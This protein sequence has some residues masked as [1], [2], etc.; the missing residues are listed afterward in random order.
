MKALVSKQPIRVEYMTL[1][2]LKRALRNPKAH[3]L[4]VIDASIRRFG[5][6]SPIVM[7]ERTGRLVAGHGRLETLERAKANG[8]KPPTRIIVKDGEWLVPVIRGV[9]FAD[10]REAEAYVVA[11]NRTTILGGWNEEE[12]AAILSDH[13]DNFSGIGYNAADL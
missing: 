10:D 4:G 13:A 2:Q 11:D 5:F 8:E 6:V 1:A 3:D 7:D 9:E 12:L